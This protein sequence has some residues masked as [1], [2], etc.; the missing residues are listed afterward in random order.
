[1]PHCWV[2]A[3]IPEQITEVSVEGLR[4]IVGESGGSASPHEWWAQR[5][6]A[7]VVGIEIVDEFRDL[8]RGVWH[9]P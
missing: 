8:R 3:Q 6:R 2:C 5:I 9:C 4:S 1:M 7:N